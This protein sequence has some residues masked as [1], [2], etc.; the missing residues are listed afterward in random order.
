MNH[1]SPHDSVDELGEGSVLVEPALLAGLAGHV[2]LAG[3]LGHLVLLE[4]L[5]QLE[6]HRRQV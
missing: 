1:F 2:P 6:H 5:R 3:R 4:R